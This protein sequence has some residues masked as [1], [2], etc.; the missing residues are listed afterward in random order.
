MGRLRDWWRQRRRQRQAWTLLRS[1][2]D[3]PSRLK[4]TSLRPSHRGRVDLVDFEWH[5]EA[6]TRLRFVILRHPRPYPFSRQFH[7]V[8]QIYR[9][10]AEDGSIAHEESL[11]LTRLRN[12]D[13]ES[14][15]SNLGGG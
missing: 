12:R 5:D 9:Y 14:P 13:G 8:A 3:D 10:E 6:I 11:N 15:G 1:L 7:E 4:G 2:F